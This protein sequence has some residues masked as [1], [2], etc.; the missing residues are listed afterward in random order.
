VKTVGWGGPLSLRKSQ[1]GAAAPDGRADSCCF[2]SFKQERQ[3][4]QRAASAPSRPL[5]APRQ[6]ASNK[7][8]FL[9]QL[10]P[11]SERLW[12]SS[13]AVSRGRRR[14]SGD[15]ILKV[16]LLIPTAI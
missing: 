1:A 4:E 10:V 6:L 11:L 8:L 14:D 5:P 7:P 3:A 13:Y 15:I 16:H 9:P 12:E 2:G